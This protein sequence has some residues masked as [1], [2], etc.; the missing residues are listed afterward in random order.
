MKQAFLLG[1][2]G[3]L[4]LYLFGDLIEGKLTLQP[5]LDTILTPF[6]GG[7]IFAGIYWL[8]RT[9][10]SKFGSRPTG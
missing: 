7:L 6:F 1:F 2:F 3:P 8:F 5:T 10:Y 9:A 4:G